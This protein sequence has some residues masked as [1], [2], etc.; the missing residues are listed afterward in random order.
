MSNRIGAI[1][2]GIA[3]IFVL[4]SMSMFTVDQRER[5][6]IFQLGEIKDLIDEGRA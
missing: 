1:L 4:A 2:A 5:A 6:I 3:A